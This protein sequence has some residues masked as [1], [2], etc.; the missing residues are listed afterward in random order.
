[1]NPGTFLRN[2]AILGGIAAVAAQLGED[3]EK[4]AFFAGMAAA[5]AALSVVT[6]IGRK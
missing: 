1:M 6:L 5:C 2:C 4:K 3:R